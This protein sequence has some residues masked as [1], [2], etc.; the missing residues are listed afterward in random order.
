MEAK[1]VRYTYA[2]YITWDDI[3]DDG[4]F[5]RYELICGIPQA[6]G[7]APTPRH[8]AISGRLFTQLTK[9]LKGKT[10]EVFAAHFEVRLNPDARDDT[11]VQPD[12]TVICDLKKIDNRGC[13]GAPDMI[14]EILSKSS[15][16]TD[17]YVKF[18]LYQD[19]GV[20]EYWIIDPQTQTLDVNLLGNGVYENS[21]Y[22][23]DALVFVEVLGCVVSLAKVFDFA[24]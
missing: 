4:S 13:K 16:R 17:R 7:P 15:A 8:Q 24:W 5:I 10:C 20:K 12:I 3:D 11:V 1:E 22:G 19:A 21:K 18:K 14:V 23:A 2:D 6:M 9:D